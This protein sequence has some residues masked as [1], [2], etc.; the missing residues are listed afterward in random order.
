MKSQELKSGNQKDS[1]VIQKG[2]ILGV[3]VIQPY[4]TGYAHGVISRITQ[5]ICKSAEWDIVLEELFSNGEYCV[6]GYLLATQTR[7]WFS[8]SGNC[9]YSPADR[10][11][12]IDVRVVK[13]DNS[14]MTPD[15]MN[16]VTKA[17]QRLLSD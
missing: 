13:G 14:R 1:D 17:L 15:E 5:Q 7:Y 8:S 12:F 4:P 11:D 16:V 3:G 9:V 6:V 10:K 2:V